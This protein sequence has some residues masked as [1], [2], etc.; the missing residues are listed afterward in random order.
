MKKITLFLFLFAGCSLFAATFTI[1]NGDILSLITVINT[2]NSNKGSDII[3]LATNRKYVFR[4]I[5]NTMTGQ[6]FSYQETDGAIALPLIRDEAV[7]GPDIIFNL[8]GS[9]LRLSST[10]S[11]MRLIYNLINASWQ[12]NGG[13]SIPVI[14]PLLSPLASN[15][16]NTKTMALQLGS[17]AIEARDGGSELVQS[18][19]PRVGN[20]DIS[21]YKYG[22]VLFIEE[23][24]S[25]KSYLTVYPNPSTDEFSI[26]IPIEYQ[27]R[28][29]NIQI[30]ALDGKP[31]LIKNIDKGG[32]TAISLTAKGI[33]N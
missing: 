14:T 3:N 2:A 18:S 25:N 27:T 1:S 9:V 13:N 31:I 19:A 11:K 23:I 16:G 6:Y 7:E 30:F 26:K 12:I 20:C 15:G 22:S 10:A 24:V 28:G 17:L 32:I 5:N 21:A 33:I 8:N 4:T 29:G